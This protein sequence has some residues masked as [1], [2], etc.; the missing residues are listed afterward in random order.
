MSPAPRT[1]DGILVLDVGS[2]IA[3][4][5]TATV[6]ADF[7]AQVIKVE[8]PDGGD[9]NRRLGELPGLP[10]SEHNYAWLLDSRNKKSLAVD[11]TKPAGR[12]GLP[13]PGARGA[14]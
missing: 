10:V 1:L 3:G 8:T 11:L 5:S 14:A 13:R 7:G 12:G 6:M 2:F 4:P 9:P